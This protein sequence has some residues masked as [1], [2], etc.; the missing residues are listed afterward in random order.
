MEYIYALQRE[1]INS[2]QIHSINVFY[3]YILMEILG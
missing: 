3:L 2:R 1:A